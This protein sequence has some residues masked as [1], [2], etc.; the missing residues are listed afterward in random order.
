MNGQNSN[1]KQEDITRAPGNGCGPTTT[2]SATSAKINPI[3]SNSKLSP[4]I[5]SNSEGS[6]P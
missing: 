3:N 5:T 6:N 1:K 4:L 2:S